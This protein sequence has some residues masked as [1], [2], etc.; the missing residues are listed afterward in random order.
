MNKDYCSKIVENINDLRK[1]SIEYEEMMEKSMDKKDLVNIYY[2]YQ[3]LKS[4]LKYK[5]HLYNMKCD[6][7]LTYLRALKNFDY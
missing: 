3:D 1:L 5:R 7:Y 4:D 6:G 2:V